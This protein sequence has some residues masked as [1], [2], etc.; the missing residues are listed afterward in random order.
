MTVFV[1]PVPPPLHAYVAPT[2]P[3]EAVSVADVTVQVRVAGGAIEAPGGVM[4]CVTVVD[5]VA[6]QPFAGSVTVTL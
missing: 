6:V 1:G 2:A 3:D 4:L 5:A